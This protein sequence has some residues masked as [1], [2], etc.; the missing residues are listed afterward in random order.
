MVHYF[1]QRLPILTGVALL[2]L[3]GV[4][5]GSIAV[6]TL[7][8]GQVSDLS[9]YLHQF[10]SSFPEGLRNTNRHA[11]ALRGVVDNIVKVSCLIWVLGMTVIGVPLIA[12]I[13][14]VRGFVLGFTVGFIIS[15]M[16]LNG[17]LVAAA[18]LLPHN[19]LFVPALILVSTTSLSF[20]VVAVQTLVGTNRS[21]IINQFMATTL[22]VV[23]MSVL[24]AL[25]ALV[26]TYVTPVLMNLS[27]MLIM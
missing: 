3:L 17:I 15:E 18:S 27:K 26:E 10:Y 4:S 9:A 7:S 19:L 21:N 22:I 6:K 2:F 11:A 20:A 25:A 5:F 12:G 23:V 14:F 1:K 16:K 24:I 8:P 13:V